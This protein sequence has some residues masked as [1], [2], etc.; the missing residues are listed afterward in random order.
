MKI[1]FACPN[2]GH[3]Y[4]VRPHNAGARVN[5]LTC[6]SPIQIPRE[7][8][9]GSPRSDAESHLP[10]FEDST[11]RL[12]LWTCG[13]AGIVVLLLVALIVATSGDGGAPPAVA[14]ANVA[15]PRP[16]AAPLGQNPAKTRPAPAAD[17]PFAPSEAAPSD[18][19]NPFAAAASA[20]DDGE[21][22]FSAAPDITPAGAS[23]APR[24]AA[25][26]PLPPPFAPSENEGNDSSAWGGAGEQLIFD[27]RAKITFG[28]LGCPVVVVEGKVWNIQ[29]R[30]LV[31]EL[32]GEYNPRGLTSLSPDGRWLVATD[33]SPNQKDTTVTVWN[34]QTGKQAFTVPGSPEGFTDLVLLSNERLFLG[35]RDA[36]TVR[37][38]DLA[39]GKPADS[40]EFPE[41]IERSNDEVALSRDGEYLAA[42][43]RDR[44]VVVKTATGKAVATMA[45]PKKMERPDKNQPPVA[46]GRASL[47][48]AT[49]IYAWLRELAFSPD[50]QELAAVSTHPIPRLMCWDQRGKLIFDEPLPGEYRFSGSLDNEL[51]W[52]PDRDAWLVQGDILDRETGRIV[53]S[54]KKQFARDLRVRVYSQDHLVGVFPHNPTQLEVLPIPWDEIRASLAHIESGGP[55]LLTP[56]E[57]VDIQIELGPIRG[58]QTEIK[59]Q[60]GTALWNRLTRDGFRVEQ[61]AKTF[62][63]LKF[64]EKAGEQLPIYARRSRFDFRGQDTGRTATEAKGSLVV[65]LVAPGRATPIWRESLKA[66]SSRSF[67]EEINNASMRK[68]MLENLADRIDELDLPYFIPRDSEELVPLPLRVR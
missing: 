37:V 29:R 36:P 42:P 20:P 22:G 48:D 8:G 54:I 68:S 23:A 9:F 49:F 67:T 26:K 52:F 35:G 46:V 27:E 28:P 11:S 65:E 64:T 51:Q 33:K 3:Q 56:K 13:G 21:G 16:S 40:V 47:T 24:P 31:C 32:E 62:F 15:A 44:M 17:K 63:R 58:D 45:S 18:S 38:W 25:R 53:L 7:D 39:A 66:T 6:R 4:Q 41:E 14:E 61:G 1:C 10:V 60:L 30:K 34:T 43:A 55:A 12:L 2:C 59:L 5:C 19:D 50:T 57:P